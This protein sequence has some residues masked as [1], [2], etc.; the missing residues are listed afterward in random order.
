LQKLRFGHDALPLQD[1]NRSKG[2]AKAK[3]DNQRL[4]SSENI[5]SD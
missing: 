4:I 3:A 5:E 2:K 1:S